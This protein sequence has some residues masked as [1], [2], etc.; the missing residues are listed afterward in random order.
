M[1]R[2]VGGE[3]GLA[4]D[5]LAALSNGAQFFRADLHIHS[6]GASHDVTD[7]AATPAAIVGEAKKEGLA[8][9]ALADHNEISNVR[10]AVEAGLT[11][12]LLARLIRWAKARAV[13]S[14]AQRVEVA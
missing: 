1:I 13:A 12:G 14:V 6:Y 3:W 10:P 5:E 4:T 11:A 9:L 8:I 7:L 2:L